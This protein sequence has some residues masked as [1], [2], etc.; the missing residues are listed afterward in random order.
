VTEYLRLVV[1]IA[2]GEAGARLAQA[3]GVAT[4][5]DTLLRLRRAAPVPPAVTLR[6]LGVDELALR[7]GQR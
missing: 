6:V 5:P 1:R 2:G 7:R 3:A 4:S